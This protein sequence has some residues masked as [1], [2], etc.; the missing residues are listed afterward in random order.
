MFLKSINNLIKTSLFP[1]CLKI[2]DITSIYKKGN[3]RPSTTLPVLSTICEKS[4]FKASVQ[5][6]ETVFSEQSFFRKG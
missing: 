2:D 5:F 1:S 6:F 3:Y 4:L